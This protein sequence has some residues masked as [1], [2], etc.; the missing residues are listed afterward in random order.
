MTKAQIPVMDGNEGDGT[1]QANYNLDVV[2]QLPVQVKVVLGSAT[3]PVAALAKL[4]RGTVVALDR[5]VGDLVEVMVN[6][7][8]VARG[9]VVI[10]EDDNARFG[11]SLTEIVG[12]GGPA[13]GRD[14]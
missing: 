4:G 10:L 6:G 7:R 5:K 1:S 2:L 9:E 13:A 3:M 8:L 11:I 12:L 14:R